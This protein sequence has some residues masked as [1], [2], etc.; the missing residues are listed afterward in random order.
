[1]KNIRKEKLSR[2][3]RS[4]GGKK[5]LSFGFILWFSRAPRVA[6]RWSRTGVSCCKTFGEDAHVGRKVS[7]VV[8]SVQTPPTIQA[9]VSQGGPD[10]MSGASVSCVRP[11]KHT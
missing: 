3:E 11:T 6:P 4:R 5:F 10:D 9:F 2:R 8:L 7:K 1:M